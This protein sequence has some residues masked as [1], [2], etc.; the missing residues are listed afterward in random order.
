MANHRDGRPLSELMTG[1]VAD[2]SGL[3][4]KEI[5]LAK[6]EASENFNK[7]LGGVE[8]LLVGLVFAIGAMGVLLTAAVNGLAVLL[9]KQGIAEV[10]ADTLSAVIVGIVV[11]LLAWAMIARGLSTLRGSSL[12]LDKT[13]ASLQRDMDVAKERVQ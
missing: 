13:A 3:F 12:R 7:A 4:R 9:V 8:I 1:L 2:I 11:A 10:N 5:D 6:A